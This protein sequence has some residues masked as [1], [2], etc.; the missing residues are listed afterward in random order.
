MSGIATIANGSFD[1]DVT[2][3]VIDDSLV[4]GTEDIILTLTATSDPS[5]SV[6]S[7]SS[8][9]KDDHGQRQCRDYDCCHDS[10]CGTGYERYVYRDDDESEFDRNDG[11]LHDRWKCE[12]WVRLCHVEW[13]R[14]DSALATQ[15]RLMLS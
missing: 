11:N 13:N 15:L 3:T 2:I 4:E 7:P 8:A 6:G 12:R 1:T 14:G 9:T 10:G 5:V